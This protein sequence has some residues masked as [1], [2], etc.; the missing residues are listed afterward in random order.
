MEVERRMEWRS[1]E[2]RGRGGGRGRT[3]TTPGTPPQLFLIRESPTLGDKNE[4]CSDHLL[5]FQKARPRDG[6][7]QDE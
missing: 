5:F 4:G 3:T 7:Q 1:A 2:G 6:T